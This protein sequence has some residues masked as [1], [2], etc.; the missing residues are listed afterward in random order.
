MLGLSLPSNAADA[1]K[2]GLQTGAAG[3]LRLT[4]VEV[5]K[6]YGLK[7]DVRDFADSTACLLALD[8]GEL[9]VANTTSQ[10]LIRAID[11]GIDVVMVI[12]AGG[13]YNVLVGGKSLNLK[14]GDWASLKAEAGIRKKAGTRLTIGVP[15]G[16]MQHIALLYEL[17]VAGIDP[18]SDV[19]IVNI[20]LAT[21]ARALEAHRVDMVMTHPVFAALAISQGD[22]VLFDHAVNTPAGKQGV[23]YIVRRRFL[24]DNPE[25]VQRIVSSQYDAMKQ[26]VGDYAKQVLL[27]KEFTQLPDDVVKLMQRDLLQYNYRINVSDIKGMAKQMF[28]LG[29]VKKDYSDEVEKYIDY[30]FLER[31]SGKTKDELAKW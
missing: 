23:G 5:E 18:E 1:V 12:G 8:Q 13:G 31:A 29:W 30:S 25:L 9:D 22:G 3:S 27:E 26:Y 6:Q 10:H 7:Y 4:L 14:P 16:S 19:E 21:H 28:D 15:T 24:K 2:L 11:E 20:P 17:K